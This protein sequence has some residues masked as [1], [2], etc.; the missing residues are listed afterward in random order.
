M[1][2]T[3]ESTPAGDLRIYATQQAS[4]VSYFVDD[5]EG[6]TM[7]CVEPGEY[8]CRWSTTQEKL[9]WL[10]AAVLDEVAGRL[11][12]P[13]DKVLCRS[14]SELAMVADPLLAMRHTWTGRRASRSAP[15][16]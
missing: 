4:V 12:C 6:G 16:R 2:L 3:I 11:S 10:R 1:L 8:A 13:A 14:M 7:L 15:R 5:G 9:D